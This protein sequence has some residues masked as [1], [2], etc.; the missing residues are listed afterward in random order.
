MER[1]D[2]SMSTHQNTT[3]TRAS[4]PLFQMIY[5]QIKEQEKDSNGSPD[6]G[7]GMGSD[8]CNVSNLYTQPFL[9][10]L[11]RTIRDMDNYHMELVYAIIR[12]YH[13]QVDRRPIFEAPYKMRK[14]RTSHFRFDI[15]NLPSDLILILGRFVDLYEKKK[16][17]RLATDPQTFLPVSPSDS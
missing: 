17:D 14:L 11:C 13:L 15:D 7:I 8:P 5:D 6:R 1:S 9:S 2:S 3:I 10:K 16:Q 12:C 4:F